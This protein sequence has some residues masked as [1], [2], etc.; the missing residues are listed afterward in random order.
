VV[1][2]EFRCMDDLGV[3]GRPDHLQGICGICGKVSFHGRTC[4]VCGLF[5]CPG[6][7]GPFNEGA[8]TIH[9]CRPHLR[10]AKWRERIW[11][12]KEQPSDEGQEP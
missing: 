5:V 8:E 12:Q 4:A 6:C 7:S 10:S 11:P 1:R 3:I 2:T 9:L